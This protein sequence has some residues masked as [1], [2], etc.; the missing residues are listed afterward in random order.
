[1]EIGKEKRISKV[2]PDHYVVVLQHV[3]NEKESL[4]KEDKNS[5]KITYEK[6]EDDNVGYVVGVG[7]QASLY[8]IG[9]KVV[10][11]KNI[12]NKVVLEKNG[13]FEYYVLL[14]RKDSVLCAI[15]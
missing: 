10:V 3:L 15:N 7:A 6:F 2:E 14:I 11:R 8:S 4:E 9:D 1:M 12:G 5:K 13:S